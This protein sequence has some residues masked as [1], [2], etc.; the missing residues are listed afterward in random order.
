M[1]MKCINGATECTGCMACQ[2]YD[3][4]DDYGVNALRCDDC[5]H[6]IYSNDRY[7]EVDGHVICLNC[8]DDYWKTNM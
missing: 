1:A 6:E 7:C 5:G 8:I 2:D 3:N 4:Y